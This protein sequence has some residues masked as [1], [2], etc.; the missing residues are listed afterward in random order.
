[1]GLCG[2]TANNSS[3]SA[4][5]KLA[6]KI[7]KHRSKEL[8]RHMEKAK[9]ADNHI[10]KLLL[11]GAGESGKST[12]FKQMIQI[13]GAGFPDQERLNYKNIIHG[14]I[15]SSIKVLASQ[16]QNGDYTAN[17]AEFKDLKDHIINDVKNDELIEN[18]LASMITQLWTTQSIQQAYIHRAKF[19]LNDSTA[20]FFER[21]TEISAMNYIPSQ[22]DVLRSRVKTT[23]VIENDFLIDGS[24]F[25][26]VDVGGQRNER[27]KW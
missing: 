10:H 19:Q 1:M 4:D 24:N 6:G 9:M 12:L 14:N 26:M 15:I 22:Q 2:S 25:K 18:K 17:P 20:Y 16:S 21:L 7:S 11:L 8:E 27:K 3:L 13:Y 5:Q 23:G